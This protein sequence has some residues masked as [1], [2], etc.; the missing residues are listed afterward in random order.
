MFV[1]NSSFEN[2]FLSAISSNGD[3]YYRA[4]ELSGRLTWFIVTCAVQNED[5]EMLQ[6][7]CCSLDEDLLALLH[8]MQNARAVSLQRVM[9]SHEGDGRWQAQ[10]IAKVWHATS[11]RGKRVLVFQ[12][13]YGSESSGPFGDMLSQ[14]LGE[15]T[16]VY[17]VAQSGLESG[18]GR[19]VLSAVVPSLSEP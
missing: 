8:P 2:Q 1:A 16:L 17:D 15:R 6:S 19:P 7:I 10:E 12:D 5:V 11:S 3:R 9:A 18:G 13:E 14:D 4:F